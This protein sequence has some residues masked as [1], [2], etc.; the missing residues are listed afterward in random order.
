MASSEFNV[1]QEERCVNLRWKGLYIDPQ[2]DLAL[3][4]G[5]ERIFWC[6]KTQRNLGPDGN[7]V[8]SYE[9]SPGRSCYKPL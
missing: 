5:D 7:L 8:D 9:C 4:Q 3:E 2:A 6:V 1:M